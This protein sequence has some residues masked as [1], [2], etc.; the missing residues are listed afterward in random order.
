[1]KNKLLAALCVCLVL[2]GGYITY[3]VLKQQNESTSR[4]QSS[5]QTTKSISYKNGDKVISYEGQNGKTALEV[6]ESV[7]DIETQD[8]SVGKMVTS[9]NGI[10]AETGKTYWAFYVDGAY[11]NE[12]AGTFVTKDGQNIQWKLE[13]IKQ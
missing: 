6:L 4:P 10:K 5:A 1:M 7:A 13:A 11:A 8:S 3:A 12:G 2:V 9:I